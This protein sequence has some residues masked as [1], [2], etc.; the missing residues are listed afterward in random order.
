MRLRPGCGMHK[1]GS[2]YSVANLILFF[3]SFEFWP[4][5]MADDPIFCKN[6]KISFPFGTNH[7]L[8]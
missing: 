4:D 8:P 3:C 5:N 6:K 2:A 7:R 1:V